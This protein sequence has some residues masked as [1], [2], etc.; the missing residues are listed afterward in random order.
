MCA[1]PLIAQTPAATGS[2]QVGEGCSGCGACI[3]TCPK[4]A[5][6]PGPARVLVFAER[7][8]VCFECIE[9]CPTGAIT[10]IKGAPHALRAGEAGGRARET[11]LDRG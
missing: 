1:N 7:C 9:I 5:L 10:E 6:A 8:S 4:G 2:I 11:A 3:V